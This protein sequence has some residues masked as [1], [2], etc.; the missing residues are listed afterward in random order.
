MPQCS[1][2]SSIPQS[3]K[4]WQFSQTTGGIERNLKL[5]ASASLPPNANALGLDEILVQV[6]STSLNPVDYKIAELP[7]LGRL[8]IGAPASPGLDFAGR[9]VLA[10]HDSGKIS[11]ENL[12]PGRLVFGRLDNPTKFGTLAEY[13]IV[14]RNGCVPLPEGVSPEDAACIGTA[15]LTAYQSLVPYL[16]SGNRVFVNGGSGGTGVFMI[17]IAKL[18]GCYVITSCSGVN[19]ELCKSLGADEVIDYKRSNVVT[20]L[21]E[22]EYVDHIVDNVGTPRELYWKAHEF[23]RKG[24]TFVQVGTSPSFATVYEILCRMLWPAILRGGKRRFQL[25]IVKTEPEGLGKIAAWIQQ[26]KLKAV[27]DEVFEM[28]DNGPVRAFEKLKTGRARGK[29]IV[30][31]AS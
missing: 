15:G 17:Q 7:L 16:K 22:M 13:V 14:S 25:L 3:M 8:T 4:A 10:G 6:I 12:G 23:S 5:K 31:V 11:S 29:M 24:T 18:L 9:V 28:E 2:S 27:I 19:V 1:M 20:A 30:R 21:K 26:G